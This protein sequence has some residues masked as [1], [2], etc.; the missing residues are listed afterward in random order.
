MVGLFTYGK[1]QK[2]IFKVAEKM[3]DDKIKF[4]FVGNL[5]LNFKD[6]WGKFISDD[7]SSLPKNIVIWD[8]QPD[9]DRFYSAFDLFYFQVLWDNLCDDF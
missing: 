2:E 1:N 4:H 3:V 5:A 7:K 6:Y 9:V 8:E